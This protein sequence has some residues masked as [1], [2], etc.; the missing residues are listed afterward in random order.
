MAGELMVEETITDCMAERILERWKET[1]ESSIVG[2]TLSFISWTTVP[3]EP[4]AVRRFLDEV[5]NYKEITRIVLIAGF[6]YRALE[7]LPHDRSAKDIR[8]ALTPTL[9]VMADCNMCPVGDRI[10]SSL[11]WCYL[12]AYSEKFKTKMVEYPWPD[13]CFNEG[14]QKIALEAMCHQVNGKFQLNK[15]TKSLQVAFLGAVKQVLANPYLLIR[16]MHYLYFLVIAKK[17]G[18]HVIELNDGLDELLCEG[19]ELSNMLDSDTTVPELKLL[20]SHLQAL[21]QT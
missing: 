3:I 11:A 9:T 2:D 17:F 21:E 15:F 12:K 1:G 10:A 5:G 14:G 4:A 6:G 13:L 16:S 8:I 7:A 18:T 19:S 20:F